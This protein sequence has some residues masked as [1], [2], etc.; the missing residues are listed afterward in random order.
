MPIF[1]GNFVY[2]LIVY[3]HPHYSHLSLELAK[4]VQHIDS[5][6]PSPFPWPVAPPA[7]FGSPGYLWRSSYRL[8]YWI[9]QLLELGQYDVGLIVL[10]VG[11]VGFL[12]E[13]H[14]GTGIR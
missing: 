9:G 8:A 4:L 2:S 7:A 5:N 6:S 12:L 1:N 13:R 10:V 11:Q 14:G 3:I